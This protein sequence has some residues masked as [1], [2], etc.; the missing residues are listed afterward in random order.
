MIAA[1]PSARVGRTGLQVSKL[2]RGLY[3][4]GILAMGSRPGA[5]YNY[6]APP[7]EIVERIEAACA[8]YDMPPPAD[9]LLP[10]QKERSNAARCRWYVAR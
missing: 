6:A 8:R 5:T 10:T 4:S 9:C 3:N 7:P 1:L 2:G